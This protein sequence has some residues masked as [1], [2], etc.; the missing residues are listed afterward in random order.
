MGEDEFGRRFERIAPGIPYS[1][2]CGATFDTYPNESE[3][4]RYSLAKSFMTGSPIE[5]VAISMDSI[6]ERTFAS[7]EGW[8]EAH[9]RMSGSKMTLPIK[10]EDGWARMTPLFSTAAILDGCLTVADPGGNSEYQTG[11]PIEARADFGDCWVRIRT[12]IDKGR[13]TVA[14]QFDGFVPSSGA[15]SLTHSSIE[16]V[17]EKVVITGGSNE[18]QTVPIYLPSGRYGLTVAQLPKNDEEVNLYIIFESAA[19]PPKTTKNN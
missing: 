19:K 16:I 15:A 7:M 14:Y 12:L 4:V 10:P 17:S 18:E 1:L 13:A 2:S 11:A 5:Q 9:V 6:L 3:H 8:N